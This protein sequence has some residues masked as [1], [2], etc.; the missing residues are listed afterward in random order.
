MLIRLTEFL[1]WSDIYMLIRLTKFLFYQLICSSIKT[2][3]SK[4][5]IT[6]HKNKSASDLVETDLER[7]ID[8]R[9]CLAFGD[10]LQN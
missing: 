9:V 6:E 7:D 4:F 5:K 1:F 3:T 10:E 8:R 2:K